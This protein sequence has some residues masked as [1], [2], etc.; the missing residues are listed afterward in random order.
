VLDALFLVVLQFPSP[1]LVAVA[2]GPVFLVREWKDRKALLGLAVILSVNTVFF[3]FYNTWDK[4][5]FLLPTFIILAYGGS[6]ALHRLWAV[7]DA[8]RSA[9]LYALAGL[10]FVASA[11]APIAIYAR[12]AHWGRTGPAFLQQ[13]F[14][15]TLTANTH[16]VGEY[17][18]N[19]NKR[20]YREYEIFLGRL[21]ESLPPGA[22]FLD[23]D[24]R[25]YYPIKYYQ[26]Y[27]NRR[28]DLRVE[29]VNVWG[30]EGWGLGRQG[31]AALLAEAYEG[32]KPLFLVSIAY[33][34]DAFIIDLRDDRYRFRKFPVGDG[35][36]V[37]QL[38]TAQAAGLPPEPPAITRVAVG[39]GFDTATHHERTSFA[40]QEPVMAA[41]YFEL[42]GEPFPLRFRWTAPDGS[43]WV[44]SPTAVPFGC[45][46]AWAMLDRPSP[47]PAGKWTVEALVGERKVGAAAFEV[48]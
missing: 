8:R 43:S 17:V 9:F 44:G 32:N 35:R 3:A 42:N 31:F 27:Y 23:D 38:L 14:G 28:R 26:K 46:S 4:F 40:A 2:A 1:F 20:H 41:A 12:L 11:V 24:S 37:Y 21:F 29:M 5:A 47:L 39:A 7:L 33:P 16:D 36:W 45:T 13:K 6:M 18:A 15:N 25:T 30:F 10:A 19:P 22:I 48:R 34:F